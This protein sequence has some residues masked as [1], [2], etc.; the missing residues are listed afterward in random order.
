MT[1]DA[2]Q[3]ITAV[4][5]AVEQAGDRRVFDR[6]VTVVGQ[7]ILLA[8]IGDVAGFRV[9]REQMVKWLVPARAYGLGNRFVPFL[10]IG[11]DRI[12]VKNDAAKIENTVAHDVTDRIAG[13]G[14]G[15]SGQFDAAAAADRIMTRHGRNL[16]DRAPRTSVPRLLA[17]IDRLR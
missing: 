6:L 16:G 5:E 2:S 7:Q 9:F 1:M 3:R 17:L 13:M 12:D 4:L 10:G 8:Y 11:E 15:R 14:N